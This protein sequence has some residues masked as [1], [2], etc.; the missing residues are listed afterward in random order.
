MDKF[1]FY[2]IDNLLKQGVDE[3]LLRQIVAEANRFKA[4]QN[5]QL[6]DACMD[7]GLPTLSRSY[8]HKWND[9]IDAFVKAHLGFSGKFKVNDIVVYASSCKDA[10][11]WFKRLVGLEAK[12]I[13]AWT[14]AQNRSQYELEIIWN[15]HKA[16]ANEEN[17]IAVGVSEPPWWCKKATVHMSTK[18]TVELKDYQVPTK[19]IE[20]LLEF[21]KSI[22]E[23]GNRELHLIKM[24]EDKRAKAFTI[25]Y[26]K[27]ASFYLNGQRSNRKAVISA[28]S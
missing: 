16:V 8:P 6:T 14:D 24:V 1:G 22:R 18:I 25:T 3:D 2:D 27:K 28:L 20:E 9:E 7:R 15:K 26:D 12:I 10:S 11:D 19:L 23:Y 21:T 4:V 5:G 17:L 13:R